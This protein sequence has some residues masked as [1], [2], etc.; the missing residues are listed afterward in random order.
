MRGED[1]TPGD[2]AKSITRTGLRLTQILTQIRDGG[3]MEEVKATRE[4]PYGLLELLE[5]ELK[6]WTRR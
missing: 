6:E 1:I 5:D 3:A 4:W 2:V